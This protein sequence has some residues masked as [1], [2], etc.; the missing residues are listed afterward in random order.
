MD[1]TNLSSFTY[2]KAYQDSASTSSLS[3]STSEQVTEQVAKR[4][5]EEAPLPK[6]SSPFKRKIGEANGENQDNQESGKKAKSAQ[7]TISSSSSAPALMP[8]TRDII[9]FLNRM[10]QNE[11]LSALNTYPNNGEIYYELGNTIA[12][13]ESIK[14]PNGETLTQQELYLRAFKCGFENAHLFNSLG[15]TLAEEDFIWFAPDVPGAIVIT[16]SELYEG[17][18]IISINKYYQ[19]KLTTK[20]DLTD[21]FSQGK[22][23]TKKD[24]YIKAIKLNQLPVAYYNLATTLE[25]EGKESLPDIS[26]KQITVQR[27]Y[28]IAFQGGFQEACIYNALGSTMQEDESIKLYDGRM[29]TQRKLYLEALKINPNYASTYYHLARM[30]IAAREDK[31]EL[32]NGHIFTTRQLYLTAIR[33]DPRQGLFYFGLATIL[34]AGEKVYLPNRVY[35]TSRQLFQHAFKLGYHEARIYFTQEIL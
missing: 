20:K 31:I 7:E 35:A 3:L 16:K 23:M 24:L 8:T 34:S 21:K 1:P 27:L 33:L 11:L 10:N 32:P 29:M 12:A 4:T 19:G 18:E 9:P 13:G 25:A 2:G 26:G 5:L 30:L 15:N 14:L 17:K 22:L 6:P 28:L